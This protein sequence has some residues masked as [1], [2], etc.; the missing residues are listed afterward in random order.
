MIS[1]I[2]LYVHVL[3]YKDVVVLR[4]GVPLCRVSIWLDMPVNLCWY[5]QKV[6]GL[7]HSEHSANCVWWSCLVK[8]KLLCATLSSYSKFYILTGKWMCLSVLLLLIVLH[9]TD[10]RKDIITS[11]Q[12]SVVYF[13]LL[14][15]TWY[16]QMYENNEPAGQ[17]TVVNLSTIMYSQYCAKVLPRHK[18]I[19]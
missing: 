2:V 10:S 1:A 18:E 7:L 11:P 9:H 14:D 4:L 5:T 8:D 17:S 12:F 3:M 16:G 13:S 19:L 6:I 15:L